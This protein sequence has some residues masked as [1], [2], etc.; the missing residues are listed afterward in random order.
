MD[1]RVFLCNFYRLFFTVRLAGSTNKSTVQ[2]ARQSVRVPHQPFIVGESMSV[3][4]TSDRFFG[5]IEGLCGLHRIPFS[6]ELA[7]QQLAA[8]FTQDALH[9]ALQVY[10]FQLAY[11]T[12]KAEKFSKEALPLVAWLRPAP[13]GVAMAEASSGT[14]PALVP[15]MILRMES[16]HILLIEAGVGQP[17]VV[18]V[19][20][21]NVR[22]SGHVTRV[23]PIAKAVTDPDG[24]DQAREAR[25]FG[26]RWFVPELLK[27]RKLWHEIVLASLVIQLI[28]LATPLFTQTIIDKVVVHHTQGTLIVIAIGMFVFMLFSAVLSWL[29]QYLVLHTGNRVDAVLGAAVF[30]RLFRL[31]PMYFQHRPTGVI[32]ARLHG[33]ETIRGFVASAAVTLVL[34]FPFLLIFV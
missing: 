32:S 28:A 13:T 31:P 33:V 22:Y 27:H 34:D 3:E 25:T 20:D 11:R 6:G 12:C 5:L 29:R 10:G 18:A 7:R 24:E 1:L 23:T 21:F 14:E 9:A 2:G 30:E 8:P 15:A 16:G 4:I 17:V 19:A 26:F